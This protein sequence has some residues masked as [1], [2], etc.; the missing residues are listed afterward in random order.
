MFS[1]ASDER[2]RS[3][4][5]SAYAVRLLYHKFA[6]VTIAAGYNKNKFNKA[7]APGKNQSEIIF[8]NL[9]IPSG[10]CCSICAEISGSPGSG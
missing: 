1:Q 2:T 10:N 7:T 3:V 9:N 4:I 8:S 5:E 6:A